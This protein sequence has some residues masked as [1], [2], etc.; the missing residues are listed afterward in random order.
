MATAKYV[1][2]KV[3]KPVEVSGVLHV[4]GSVFRAPFE[5]VRRQI[6]HRSLVEVPKGTKADE[7]DDTAP[8]PADS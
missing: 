5:E 4:V 2:V 6:K 1:Y 3:M 7:S 8:P